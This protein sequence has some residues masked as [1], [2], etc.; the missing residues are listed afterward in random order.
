MNNKI[1]DYTGADLAYLLSAKAVREKS[2]R[3]YELVAQ[4]AGHFTI[5]LEKMDEVV[6]RVLKVTQENY[7]TLQI[8]FH[9]RWGHFNVGGRDRLALLDKNF[10]GLSAAEKARGK[11]DLVVV[12]VLL[13][14]GAGADWQ[15]T[16][17]K[18]DI[19]FRS[20]GLA[21][22]SLEMFQRGVF[23]AEAGDP[24]RVDASRL[25]QL[26]LQDLQTAFQ[27]SPQNKLIG[28]AGRLHLL[29]KLGAALNNKLLFAEC[30][31]GNI[32][33]TLYKKHGKAFQVEDILSLVLSG[34]GSIW[35]GRITVGE[36]PLGDVWH[37]PL[38][39]DRHAI[40]GL[41][42]FHKLSQWM[43]YSLVAPLQE[44]GCEISGAEKM[45]G[46]PEYR[47]GGL[48]L[49][50]GVL[51][52]VDAANFQRT[53]SADS[54]FIVE[55]RALTVTLLDIVADLMRKKLGLSEAEFPL[56]KVLEGGTWWAGREIAKEKRADGG[57][58]LKIDSDGT[59]F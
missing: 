48:F 57:A 16:D 8:P 21:V 50:S 20:E 31:A 44:A 56:A 59:V 37:H 14:A 26:S 5:H 41:I 43:T 39:G 10:A 55:W 12:S 51:K 35:P 36:T 19:F 25:Q 58:P 3:L 4:G 54:E 45:T 13:D 40:S 34:F 30:R 24:Y 7:P 29:E 15:Y 11:I 18:G 53:H 32:Y 42:P 49:D 38:L 6:E 28:V 1:S 52:L 2:L 23:S 22:A 9:S 27:V 47:N 17:Q 46:L 33:D